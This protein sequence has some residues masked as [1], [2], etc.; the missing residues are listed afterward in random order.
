MGRFSDVAT[1]LAEEIAVNGK[2][3]AGNEKN[4]VTI[5]IL[6]LADILES[7]G[8][9]NLVPRCFPMERMS[10]FL[11]RVYYEERSDLYDMLGEQP[12]T[13]RE[14]IE[15]DLYSN[16]PIDGLTEDQKLI[17]TAFEL[18]EAMSLNLERKYAY[19]RM[20]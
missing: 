6:D 11:P 4:Y 12:A 9:P 16:Q 17:F 19:A 7:G 18:V 14:A 15:A 13:L 3:E 2:T 20:G 10:D 8:N 5:T 1:K